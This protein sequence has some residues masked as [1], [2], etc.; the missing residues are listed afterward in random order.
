MFVEAK[1]S[2]KEFF[3]QKNPFFSSSVSKELKHS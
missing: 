1:T 3:N 2:L